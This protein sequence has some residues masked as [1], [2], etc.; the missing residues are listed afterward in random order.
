[1]RSAKRPRAH[2][3]RDEAASAEI[4]YVFTV[5]LSS[6]I[7]TAVLLSLTKAVD[8]VNIATGQVEVDEVA[9][10]VIMGINN[11]QDL[12]QRYPD[13]THQQKIDL[14]Q[15]GFNYII[16]GLDDRLVVRQTRNHGAS[17]E[18]VIY[19]DQNNILTG[20]VYSFSPS[21]IIDY[22]PG[23]NEILLRPPTMDG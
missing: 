12:A 19:H 13:V 20:K 8:K 4:S 23:S 11:I 5:F 14:P 6:M 10:R 15:H 2:P 3:C 9:S 21:L 7:M 16:M 22:Q 1:M 17:I 18:M